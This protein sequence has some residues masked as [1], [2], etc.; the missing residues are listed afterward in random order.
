VH[1]TKVS[2]RRW[3]APAA[4]VAMTAVAANVT[5]L[6][7]L[8]PASATVSNGTGRHPVAAVHVASLAKNAEW[9]RVVDSVPASGQVSLAT[10]LSAFAVAIGRVPGAVAPRGTV[11][12]IES[13]TIA[14]DWVLSHWSQLTPSQQAAVLGDLGQSKSSAVAPMSKADTT[15]EVGGSLLLDTLIGS[16]TLSPN[17]ACPS[18][19]SA[20]AASYRAQVL[21]I[22]QDIAAD[23]GVGYPDPVYLEVNTSNVQVDPGDDSSLMY[24]YGCSG[25]QPTTGSAATVDAC[26]IHI[27]PR[28]N[29]GGIGTY[30]SQDIH[31]DLIHELTHCLLFEHFG[32]ATYSFPAWYGEGIPTWVE[33]ELGGGD[34]TAED[35]WQQ[36][37]VSPGLSLFTRTYTGLGFFV[38]LDETGTDVWHAIVPI[39]AALVASGN[40]N[41]AGWNAAA[42]TSKFLDSWGSGYAQG[43][44]TGSAWSS[45]GPGLSE[46]QAP[47]APAD[48]VQDDIPVVVQ[49]NAAATNIQPVDIDAQVVQVGSSSGAAGRVSLGRDQDVTLA[50]AAGVNYCSDSTPCSCPTGSSNSGAT[51]SPIVSG[52]QYATVTGGT[53]A[54][55]VTLTGESLKEFCSD[56]SCI[57]G[58]FTV[59]DE[60]SPT[61]G[62]VGGA[63]GATWTVRADG[64]WA[65]DWNGSAPL[66]SQDGSTVTYTGTQGGTTQLPKDPKATSGTLVFT[67]ESGDA[68]AHNSDGT[69]EALPVAGSTTDMFSCQGDTVTV[70]VPDGI[71][72]TLVTTLHRT[73]N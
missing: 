17:A 51:F 50:N 71:G 9:A 73:G 28:I 47:L 10:A 60:T 41:V 53:S 8:V 2:I 1:H 12:P 64:S 65:I 57:V 58:S 21:P 66:V 30:S 29:G 43:R 52:L 27:Q 14:V 61:L 67:N 15:P 39:G 44:Y 45:I 68:V 55:T 70:D 46:Y 22:E 35:Y 7:P 56:A 11:A 26:V 62:L 33:T 18:S 5:V 16:S 42:P 49:S 4:L 6:G 20:G 23:T 40:S 54:A 59:T 25:S 69:S 31:A 72:D 37:L 3:L 36:Y 13:G 19:D 48:Q 32:G 38:H 24:T 34:S 63:A